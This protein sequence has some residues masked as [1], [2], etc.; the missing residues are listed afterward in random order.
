MQ[1]D[2]YKSENQGFKGFYVNKIDS[3]DLSKFGDQE[4]NPIVLQKYV[5]KDFEVRYT[6][7]GNK[8]FACRINSQ[9]SK[10]AK[11]DWRRYDIPNTPHFAIDIPV[12]IKDKVSKLMQ[13]LQIEYGA[14]D[15]IVTKEKEWYFLEVNSMGQF[16]WIEDLTGLP[17]S[18]VLI[19]WMQSHLN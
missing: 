17:I 12:E 18:E 6:V 8:H 14:L 15:F 4:E 1:Q 5:D 3:N 10:L 19:E 11:V 2:F 16:L 13:K 9:E 7:V